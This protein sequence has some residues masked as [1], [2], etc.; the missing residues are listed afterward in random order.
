MIPSA[1]R[2]V[3]A[4]LRRLQT[5]TINHDKIVIYNISIV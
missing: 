5:M 4:N 2:N 1:H 3:L